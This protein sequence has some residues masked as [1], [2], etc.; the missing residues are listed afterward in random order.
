M[1]SSCERLV[2]L[3]KVAD[4]TDGRFVT[5]SSAPGPSLSVTDPINFLGHDPA[6][7]TGKT[8]SNPANP[9]AD[10]DVQGYVV[11]ASLV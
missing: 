5:P 7:A 1:V 9:L 4:S 2:P 8:R 3:P 10:L 6:D 11:S